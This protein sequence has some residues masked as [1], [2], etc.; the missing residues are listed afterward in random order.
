[1]SVK[2][3]L[4]ENTLIQNIRR[5]SANVI[6]SAFIIAFGSCSNDEVNSPPTIA[7]ITPKAGVAGMQVTITGEGFSTA[8][9]KNIIRF[10]GVDAEVLSASATQLIVVVPEVETTG[11]VLVTV[12]SNGL[13]GPSFRYY[14]VFVLYNHFGNGN[15]AVKVLKNTDIEPITDGSRSVRGYSLVVDGDDI[16]IAGDVVESNILVP[17]YW[18]NNVEQI[19]P[20]VGGRG[21]ASGIALDGNDVYVSGSDSEEFGANQMAK[22]W[23]NNEP[24]GIVKSDYYTSSSSL[25]VIDGDIYIGGA[26]TSTVSPNSIPTYWKNGGENIMSGDRLNSNIIDMEMEGPD[27]YAL[28]FATDYSEIVYWK[29]NELVPVANAGNPAFAKSISVS[30]TD[31]FIAGNDV[32]TVSKARLWK[33]GIGEDVFEYDPLVDDSQAVKVISMD[34]NVIVLA[35]LR[36]MGGE[37]KTYV[38]FNEFFMQLPLDK[39]MDATDLFIR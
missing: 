6:V 1:M 3:A 21:T 31:V 25:M 10:N 20:T 26:I 13:E 19:L 36:M 17:A 35:Y 16:H 37:K 5:T 27:L 39:D 30:G 7:E 9:E 12:G 33:N 22:F 11:T 32:S 38:K 28:G 23:K 14:E 15:S 4:K 18:K 29:N 8:L 24:T 34:G 2:H